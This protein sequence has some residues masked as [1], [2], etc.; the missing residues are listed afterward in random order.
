MVFVVG[1]MAG[2]VFDSNRGGSSQAEGIKIT[3]EVKDGEKYL[4]IHLDRKD[5]EETELNDIINDLYSRIG[6]VTAKDASVYCIQDLRE[7]YGQL[8]LRLGEKLKI[9]GEDLQNSFP[10]VML[11]TD[12]NSLLFPDEELQAVKEKNCGVVDKSYEDWGEFRPSLTL[13]FELKAIGDKELLRSKIKEALKLPLGLFRDRNTGQF[14]EK[15]CVLGEEHSIR[16]P[17]ETKTRLA[18]K[19]LCTSIIND[20]K[21]DLKKLEADELHVLLRKVEER[22][23]EVCEVLDETKTFPQNIS[24]RISK[25]VSS[26]VRGDLDDME[27][28]KLYYGDSIRFK[29]EDKW[30]EITARLTESLSGFEL[31]ASKILFSDNLD[32]FKKELERI[33]PKTSVSDPG[34]K[35]YYLLPGKEDFLKELK[36][37]IYPNRISSAVEQRKKEF[38]DDI[39]EEVDKWKCSG[40][41][42]EVEAKSN[43]HLKPEEDAL[44]GQ[45]RG[46]PFPWSERKKE[47]LLTT[48][49]G[50]KDKDL[51][52]VLESFAKELPALKEEKTEVFHSNHPLLAWNK[53]NIIDL[54]EG[55]LLLKGLSANG[56]GFA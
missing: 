34:K 19:Y 43:I 15:V 51:S 56:K 41:M 33:L 45:W 3:E 22:Y 29:W 46:V 1:R 39:A 26:T 11:W 31:S 53:Q 28:E 40:V 8:Y 35:L 52:L 27:V 30:N 20:L 47:E 50:R 12:D 18:E 2:E 24:G 42:E 38:V 32:E 17:D 14:Y 54:G 48:L 44:I 23:K 21:E 36:E 49:Q 7:D 37:T 16:I 13:R 10:F 6:G 4:L 25:S 55:R 9:L 5:I